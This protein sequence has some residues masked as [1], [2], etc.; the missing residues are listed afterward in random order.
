MP[1]R[2]HAWHPEEAH[3]LV[4]RLAVLLPDA[5]G[6]ARPL[7]Q[8]NI[9]LCMWVTHR[10]GVR[11]IYCLYHTRYLVPGTWYHLPGTSTCTAAGYL[12]SL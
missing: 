8:R 12:V 4:A 6:S 7:T 9:A 11:S 2:G 3:D 1:G 10:F 5:I